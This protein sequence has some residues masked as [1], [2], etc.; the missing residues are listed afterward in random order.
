MLTA[1]VTAA[2]RTIG[3]QSPLSSL[4]YYRTHVIQYPPLDAHLVILAQS[5]P[6]IKSRICINFD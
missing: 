6:S 4:G 3:F 5:Q 1:I 2:S